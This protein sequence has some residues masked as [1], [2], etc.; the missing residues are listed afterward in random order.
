MGF[1]GTFAGTFYGMADTD[2]AVNNIHCKT[3]TPVH[4]ASENRLDADNFHDGLKVWRDFCVDIR[5]G[6]CRT[7]PDSVY[8]VGRCPRP[9]ARQRHPM[10][11]SRFVPVF[12]LVAVGVN[13]EQCSVARRTTQI[14]RPIKAGAGQGQTRFGI[15]A[16]RIG[17]DSCGI[18]RAGRKI[19]QHAKPGAVGVQHEY[20][21]V[22]SG[23]PHR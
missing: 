4:D 22:V 2:K 23:T 11:P 21:A 15:H 5:Y 12:G 19:P 3:G 17:Q 16:I 14:R 7:F 20:R 18:V 13:P 8:A 1:A 10:A 9:L 6:C